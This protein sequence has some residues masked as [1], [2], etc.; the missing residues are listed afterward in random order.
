M[1]WLNRT[2]STASA[3]ASNVFSGANRLALSV[4]PEPVQRRVT[5]LV[6]GLLVP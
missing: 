5:N 1:K 3:A 2:R 6:T 4:I